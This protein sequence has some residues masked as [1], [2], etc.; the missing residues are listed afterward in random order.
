ME[1]EKYVYILVSQS[2]TGISKMLRRV[3]HD[4][5]NHV[6]LALDAELQKMYSYGRRR[7]HN[8]LVGG[9]VHETPQTGVFGHYP[10]ADAVVVK[11]PMSAE[12]YTKLQ[13]RMQEMYRRRLEYRYDFLGLA[14]AFF[15]KA[16]ERRQ[17][18][19]CSKFVAGELRTAGVTMPQ[20]TVFRPVDFLTLD[21]GET[22]FSGK[23]RAYSPNRIEK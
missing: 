20:K 2:G 18:S 9:F 3:T 12:E 10:E 21:R 13:T 7:L 19:Y 22:V 8:P 1:Q 4:P 14:L 17:K 6:S 16:K 23:L 11:L 15:G 5:Y